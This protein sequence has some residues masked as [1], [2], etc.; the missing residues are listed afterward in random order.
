M[1]GIQDS[2]I[3][4]ALRRGPFIEDSARSRLARVAHPQPLVKFALSAFL[5]C[6]LVPSGRTET[7]ADALRARNYPKAAA[8]LHPLVLDSEYNLRGQDPEPARQLALLYSQ[9]LGVPQDKTGAC[10]LAQLAR[11]VTGNAAPNYARDTAGYDASLKRGDRFIEEHCSGLSPDEQRNANRSIGCFALTMPEEV[12][13]AGGTLVRVGRDG[14]GVLDAPDENIVGL[15]N[16]PLYVA[17]V[18]ATTVEPP[19]GA[20]PGVKAR[21]VI[22]MFFWTFAH[23]DEQGRTLWTLR[24]H[25]YEVAGKEIVVGGFAELQRSAWP[26][27]PAPADLESRLSLEMDKRG[28]VRWEVDGSSMKSG[29]LPSR[30]PITPKLL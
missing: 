9:G 24:W 2:V 19:P 30:P 14:I 3:G 5:V 12:L 23:T 26:D 28:H 27:S 15:L 20:A 17:R 25:A 8:L 29:F 6:L 11:L 7:W 18:R 16:C 22:E 13:S 4:A 1:V 10:A 21:H